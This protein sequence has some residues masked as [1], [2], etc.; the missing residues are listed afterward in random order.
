MKG[1]TSFLVKARDALIIILWLV[2]LSLLQRLNQNAFRSSSNKVK[3]INE[4]VI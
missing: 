3:K 2:Y 1:L 4:G